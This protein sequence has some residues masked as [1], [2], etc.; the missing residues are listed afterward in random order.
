MQAVIDTSVLIDLA[1]GRGER[2]D[3]LQSPIVPFVV[4]AEMQAGFLRST[5]PEARARSMWGLFKKLGA[6]VHWPDEQTVTC[7]ASC[8]AELRERLP[9][10]VRRSAVSHNDVWV[11][12]TAMRLGLPLMTADRHHRRFEHIQ[13]IWSRP[14]LD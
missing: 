2:A 5:D 4:L 12:A 6:D 10:R 1:E 11:A 8:M 13:L 14:D 9:R 7:W 3:D